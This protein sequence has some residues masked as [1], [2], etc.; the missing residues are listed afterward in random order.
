MWELGGKE[1][2]GKERAE[3]QIYEGSGG[4]W[5]S[6]WDVSQLLFTKICRVHVTGEHR[7]YLPVTTRHP[8]PSFLGSA[9][10]CIFFILPCFPHSFLSYHKSCLVV[11]GQP[12]AG[13]N[14]REGWGWGRTA[15]GPPGASLHGSRG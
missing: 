9:P 8:R 14:Q 5:G 4:P 12:H 13:L 2:I 6:G 15:P 11:G 3:C 7:L 1:A 10:C